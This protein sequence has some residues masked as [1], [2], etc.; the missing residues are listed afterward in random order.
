MKIINLNVSFILSRFYFI[1]FFLMRFKIIIYIQI[2]ILFENNAIQ[3][4]QIIYVII[5]EK[6]YIFIFKNSNIIILAL[7]HDKNKRK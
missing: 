4:N 2:Y 5:N 6:I 3:F 7:R 1:W